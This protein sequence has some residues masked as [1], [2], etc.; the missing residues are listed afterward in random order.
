MTENFD[1]PHTDM[2][3]ALPIPTVTRWFIRKIAVARP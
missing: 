3:V 1:D 2:Q